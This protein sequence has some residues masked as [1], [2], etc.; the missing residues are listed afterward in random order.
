MVARS[1]RPTASPGSADPHPPADVTHLVNL[2][3]PLE[4]GHP[5]PRRATREISR[6]DSPGHNTLAS[7]LRPQSFTHALT[8]AC[9]CLPPQR[10]PPAISRTRRDLNVTLV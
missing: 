4:P 3:G 8:I 6:L 2:P 1:R 10:G 5:T 9:R 7:T